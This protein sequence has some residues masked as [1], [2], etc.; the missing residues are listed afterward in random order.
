MLNIG[1]DTDG[2]AHQRTTGVTTHEVLQRT[3]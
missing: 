1:E 2:E 3:I